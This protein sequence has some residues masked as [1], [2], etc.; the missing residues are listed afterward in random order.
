MTEPTTTE[1]T[2]APATEATPAEQRPEPFARKAKN[3]LGRCECSQWEIGEE[4]LLDGGNEDA[5]SDITIITTGCDKT[6]KR[7]FAQGHDAKLKSLFIRAGVEGLDVRWG[8]ETG[9]LV[10]TDHEAAADRFGFGHQVRKAVLARLDK[11]AKGGKKIAPAPRTVQA[12]VAEGSEEGDAIVGHGPIGHGE[13]TIPEAPAEQDAWTEDE[14]PA[15]A[16]AEEGTVQGKVGRWTYTG[17]VA[18]DG[19]FIYT[20]GNGEQKVADAGKWSPIA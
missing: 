11:L 1:Q 18:A 5:G 19:A 7:D 3:R 4:I 15:E 12:E 14:A 10:T 9:V 13:I 8:R 6:T 16:P 2:T 17:R 20:G